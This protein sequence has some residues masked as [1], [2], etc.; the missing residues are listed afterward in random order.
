MDKYGSLINKS[1]DF[2]KRIEKS[3]SN[4][5]GDDIKIDI[6]INELDTRNSVP[7]RIWDFINRNISKNFPEEEY[8][9]KPTKRGRW[10]MKPIFEKSTGILYTLMREE[11]LSELKKEVTKRKSAHY[12]QA[13]SEVLNKELTTCG[14]QLSLF[15]K[16][17][18]YA[19]EKIREIVHK[20]FNDLSIPDNIVKHHA[21]ILFSSNN[22]ELVSLKCCIVKSDLSIVAQSDWSNYIEA[23]ESTVAEVTVEPE[24]SY[25]N[26]TSGLKLKQKAKDKIGQGKISDVKKGTEGLSKDK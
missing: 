25:M 21:I 20:I 13:L 2:I 26:P 3:L 11:R 5:I 17:S 19:E 22:Y 14:E 16:Q 9:A 10:E 23:S 18:Y 4:A 6:K 12:V 15:E 7:N 8:V 24:T 1:P